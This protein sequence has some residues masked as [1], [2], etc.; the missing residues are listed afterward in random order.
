MIVKFHRRFIWNICKFAV[1]AKNNIIDLIFALKYNILGVRY[2][3]EYLILFFLPFNY[4]GA[5]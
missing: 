4:N 3:L 1:K 2:F 5:D